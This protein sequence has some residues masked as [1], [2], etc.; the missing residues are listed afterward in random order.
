MLTVIRHSIHRFRAWLIAI[1]AIL[2]IASVLE[3]GH[4]HGVFTPND[5]HCT[6][7]QHAFALDKTLLSSASFIV[8]L[9]LAVVTFRDNPNFIPTIS[10]HFALI[11]APPQPLQ[12]R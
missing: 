1:A 11:R 6:L 2:V 9:L 12:H 10:H 7:C 5:D 4:A 3:A 8:L